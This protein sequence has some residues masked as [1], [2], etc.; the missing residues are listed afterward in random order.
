MTEQ[1]RIAVY[2]TGNSIRPERVR[3]ADLA[4]LMVA[5]EN[6]VFGAAQAEQPQVTRDGLYLSLTDVRPGSLALS[7]RPSMS[8]IGI[9]AF[10]QLGRWLFSDNHD[11][12][13]EAAKQSL[14]DIASFAKKYRC[15]VE[16]RDPTTDTVLAT[17]TEKTEFLPAPTIQMHTTLYG[18]V[19]ETGGKIPNVH[20]ELGTGEIV[21]CKGSHELVGQLGSRLYKWVGLDGVGE[22]RVDSLKIEK[23]HIMQI[24]EFQD[25]PFADAMA[26]LANAVDGRMDDIDPIAFVNEMRRDDEVV[27]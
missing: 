26:N 27:E 18:Y 16:L 7:F 24:L 12:I 21:I 4:Q 13:P 3:A 15:S 8:D 20:L 14:K 25:T 17:I 19:V 22:M 2:C 1:S 23:F 6:S 9:R 10:Q 11:R 5:V